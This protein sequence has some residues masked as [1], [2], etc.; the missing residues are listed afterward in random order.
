MAKTGE[1]IAKR[2][3]RALFEM[4]PQAR[5]EVISSALREIADL[6]NI[7]G[8]LRQTLRNPSYNIAERIMV[9]RS[10]AELHLAGDEQ[11]SNFMGLLVDN[12]R[13]AA[14]PVIE[15]YFARFLAELKKIL[16]LTV[17]SA[18]PLADE[19][20]EGILEEIK[21]KHGVLA[22]IEWC[23]EPDLI[24]GLKIQSGDQLY[25]RSIRGEMAQLEQELLH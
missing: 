2:Y 13:I 25:D 5:L 18:F 23:V 14:L 16:T 11:F 8:D 4:Y 6:W 3:A 1:K 20:K 15:R 7:D 17:T 19:E 22:S 24:G 10:I 9:A 12:G 21:Q